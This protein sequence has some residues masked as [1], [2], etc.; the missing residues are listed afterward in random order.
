MPEIK[1][2]NIDHVSLP[3]AVGEEGK[4]TDPLVK[5]KEFY[6]GI[7]GL[8]EVVRPA[9]LVKSIKLGAWYQ[10]GE[11]SRTLH[12]IANEDGKSTFRKD[13]ELSSRDIHFALRISNFLETLRSLI[14]KGYWLQ[15]HRPEARD[16]A[17]DE[18]DLKEMRVSPEGKAGFPQIFIMDPDRNVIELNVGNLLTEEELKLVDEELKKLK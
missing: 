18:L 10:V 17:G 1:I 11:S 12:L 15:D 4:E 13:K 14:S 8:K 2:E 16:E 7:L 6:S 5:S 9:A 3:V